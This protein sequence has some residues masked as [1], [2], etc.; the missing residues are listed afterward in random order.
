MVG[1]TIKVNIPRSSYVEANDIKLHVMRAGHTDGEPV[2]L[3]H[4][5][6]EFWYGWHNQITPLAEE[7]YHLIIPDQ[8]GYN[9]SDKPN[10]VESYRVEHLV[11]DVIGLLDA[12]EYEKVRLVAHDWGAIVAWYAAMWHPERFQQLTIM[13][14]PHPYIFTKF[15]SSNPSQMMK[16]WYAGAF[17]IPVLPE[18]MI[19]FND[20]KMFAD[21]MVKEAKLRDDELRRYKDA[22]AQPGA[23]TAMVN[24]YRAIARYS[25][26]KKTDG[27]IRV[28]TLMLWGKQDFALSAEMVEPS[29]AMCD[30]GRF[31]F[32]EGSGHFVQHERDEQ[33]NQY[34]LDFFRGDSITNTTEA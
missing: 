15:L 21:V 2:L 11:A 14:V 7:G 1:E 32:F 13:N 10:G 5:F 8:R 20:F 28:Q 9:L 19:K 23:M 12:L 30:D 25:P 17:Q 34:L 27:R 29:I 26:E 4:G 24:W 31:V 3:L 33:I 22:W 6:P 18:Q 16:S